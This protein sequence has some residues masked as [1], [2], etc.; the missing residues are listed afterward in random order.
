MAER[1]SHPGRIHFFGKGPTIGR[2]DV[3]HIPSFI[4]NCESF[5]SL[6]DLNGEWRIHRARKTLRQ[7]V[8]SIIELSGVVLLEHGGAPLSERQWRGSLLVLRIS[9]HVRNIRAL[10]DAVQIRLAVRHSWDIGGRNFRWR[11]LSN[12]SGRKY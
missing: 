1:S 4:K 7:T 5:G 2:S 9:R 10:P 6:H 3:K 11:V 12:C 8:A